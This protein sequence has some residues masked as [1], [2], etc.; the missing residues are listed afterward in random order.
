ME[1]YWDTFYA[2]IQT[3][4]D[5][6]Y[7]K[8]SISDHFYYIVSSIL[9]TATEQGFKRGVAFALRLSSEV[10]STP[11]LHRGEVKEE[12]GRLKVPVKLNSKIL[13]AG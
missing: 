3:Y 6:K 12:Y 13:E 10:F 9:I 4:S 2:D 5:P 8:N 1:F 11:D 7:D